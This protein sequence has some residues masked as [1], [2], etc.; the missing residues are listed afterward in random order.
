M[1]NQS[2]WQ[3]HITALHAYANRE[4]H[5]KVPTNHIETIDGNPINLGTWVSYTRQRGRTGLLSPERTAEL[6]QIEGWFWNAQR[7]GPATDEQRN[8]DIMKMRDSGVS[9]QKIGD[10][11]GISRQRVHQIVRGL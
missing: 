11:F 2:R 5:T 8:A 1:T 3:T 6:N 7:P 10:H 9:L 4:H